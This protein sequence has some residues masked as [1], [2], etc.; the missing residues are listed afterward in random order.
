MSRT[1]SWLSLSLVVLAGLGRVSG[2][3]SQQTADAGP[4]RVLDVIGVTEAPGRKTSVH[5]RVAAPTTTD[6]ATAT[7]ETLRVLG[8]R[9]PAAGELEAQGFSIAGPVWSQFLDHRRNDDSLVQYY[10]PAQ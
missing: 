7:T 2:A 5:A 6:S 8:A 9:P 4:L 3:A 1:F 10:N